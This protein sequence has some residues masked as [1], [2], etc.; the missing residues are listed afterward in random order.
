MTAAVGLNLAAAPALLSH[1]DYLLP[2][3]SKQLNPE[4]LSRKDFKFVAITIDDVPH[5]VYCEQILDVL[6]KHKARATFFVNGG[7]VKA[8]PDQARKMVAAGH[9]IGNHSYSHP[10]MTSLSAA[11][12]ASEISDTQRIVKE[13][14]GVTPVFFRPPFGDF[15]ARV[16]KAIRDAGLISL[17]WSI[18]TLDWQLP[19]VDKIVSRALGG[20]HNGA[21]ILMH[22]TNAQTPAALDI[23]LSSLEKN[24]YVTVTA[25]EWFRLAGG[26]PPEETEPSKMPEELRK[27]LYDTEDIIGPD[28]TPIRIYIPKSGGGEVKL[29]ELKLAGGDGTDGVFSNLAYIENEDLPP[30]L[31]TRSNVPP[32]FYFPPHNAL[33]LVP[34]GRDIRLVLTD[35]SGQEVDPAYYPRPPLLMAVRASE[36]ELLDPNRLAALYAAAGFDAIAIVNDTGDD[37]ASFQ[38]PVKGAP[39]RTVVNKMGYPI[40]CLQADGTL[41]RNYIDLVRQKRRS[42]CILVTPETLGDDPVVGAELVRFFRFRQLSGSF[43]YD[44][45]VD[46]RSRW[47]MPADVEIARFTGYNRIV[48][49]CFSRTGEAHELIVKSEDEHLEAVAVTETGLQTYTRLTRGTKVRIAAEPI[50]L[51]YRWGDA[52]VESH[53]GPG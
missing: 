29:S 38:S 21:V 22:G 12:L 51:V 48:L 35:S 44:P 45:A 27:R 3:D 18:D 36:L 47:G 8:F 13:T 40:F 23:I 28:G 16:N 32:N 53:A 10:R 7:R 17:L 52:A 43:T 39:A 24:G 34:S 25:S 50:Y 19:G 46:I 31:G 20:L 11:G 42:I 5:P 26:I 14:C 1:R 6:L 49:M 41:L 33:E 30:G 4:A 9:E 15:D 37:G 2:N